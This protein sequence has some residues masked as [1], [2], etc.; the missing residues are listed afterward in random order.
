MEVIVIADEEQE[1]QQL[2]QDE[3]GLEIAKSE[4]V[5][6]F[7]KKVFKFAKYKNLSKIQFPH[8]CSFLDRL[9]F[10]FIRDLLVFN[11]F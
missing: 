5:T 2:F 1:T 4:L 6:I 3:Q 9:S 10:Q 7:H 8:N 11:F